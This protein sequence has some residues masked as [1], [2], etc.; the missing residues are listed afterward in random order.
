M[1]YEIRAARD[2]DASAVSTVILSALRRT[3][4]RDY[5]EEIIRRVER[6][7]SPAGVLELMR[8]RKV[9]VA[10]EGAQIVGTASLDGHVVRTVFVDP[11]AQ[12]RGVGRLLMAAVEQAAR[13]AGVGT[14]AVPSSVTAEQFYAKLGFK[15]VRDSFHGKERTIIMQRQVS[16]S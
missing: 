15:A 2:E 6:S 7:F 5:S 8:N 3:N 12:G 1:N 11:D 13:A 14:L 16:G 10:A 4:A 9:F